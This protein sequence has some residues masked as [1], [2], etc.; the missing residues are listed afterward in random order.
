M[1]KSLRLPIDTAA[2]CVEV[3]ERAAESALLGQHVDD[4]RPL[5]CARVSWRI[6]IDASCRAMGS[7][8]ISR[9]ADAARGCDIQRRRRLLGLLP[10]SASGM[11]ASR[12]ATSALNPSMMESSSRELRRVLPVSAF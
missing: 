10:V 4:A 11:T 1:M 6:E 12:A 5:F 8:F 9:Y 7:P 3:I 2:R